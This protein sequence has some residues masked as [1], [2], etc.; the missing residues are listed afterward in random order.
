MCGRRKH[1]A[2]GCFFKTHPDRNDNP[3]LKFTDSEKGK[4]YQLKFCHG[5]LV[6]DKMLTG[7]AQDVQ[8]FL[9]RYKTLAGGIGKSRQVLSMNALSRNHSLPTTNAVFRSKKVS[10]EARLGFDSHAQGDFISETLAAKLSP[11]G[12]RKFIIIV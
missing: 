5:F 6:P 7:S 11:G 8:T 3:L 10:I 2:D 4:S 1:G 9:A 12:L